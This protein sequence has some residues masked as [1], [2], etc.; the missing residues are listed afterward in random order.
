MSEALSLPEE[1]PTDV[2]V[3]PEAPI[4]TAREQRVVAALFASFASRHC[5]HHRS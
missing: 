1:A 2:R 5:R 4:V 3:R